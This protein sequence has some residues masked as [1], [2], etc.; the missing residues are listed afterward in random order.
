MKKSK[1]LAGIGLV[2]GLG[3]G[4][5]VGITVFAPG[6]S[7]AQTSTSP[8][9]VAPAPGASTTPEAPGTNEATETHGKGGGFDR[10][11]HETQEATDGTDAALL[12]KATITPAQATAAALLVAPGTAAAPDIH[13]RDG[14]LSYRVEVTTSSGVVEVAVDAKTGVATIETEGN[15]HHGGSNDA[16]DVGQPDAP[17]ATLGAAAAA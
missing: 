4:G 12:A 8:A 1:S 15:E 16:N 10:A 7:N 3:I 17:A 2:A 6:T 11:A 13:D 9:V 5:L 14:S